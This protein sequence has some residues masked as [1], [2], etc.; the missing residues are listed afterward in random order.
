MPGEQSEYILKIS[1]GSERWQDEYCI[2]L[3]DNDS[4]IQKIDHEQFDLPGGG[5][6][7]KTI[8][9]KFPNNFK[10]ALGLCVII[11]Q[12]A[13]IINTLSIGVKDAISTGWPDIRTCPFDS[14]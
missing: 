12:R 2:L 6:E 4:V 8:M 9:I 1:N 3:I 13:T 10:G 14:E 11:P 7:Q 5:E